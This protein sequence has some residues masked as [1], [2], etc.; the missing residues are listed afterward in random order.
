MTTTKLEY[1][2]GL[3]RSPDQEDFMVSRKRSFTKPKG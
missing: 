3:Y 1:H 2:M